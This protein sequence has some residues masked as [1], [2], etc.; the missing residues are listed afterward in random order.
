MKQECITPWVLMVAGV[1][2]AAF[3]LT[4]ERIF[5]GM[6]AAVV[7]AFGALVFCLGVVEWD[8]TSEFNES[9]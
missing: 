5:D 4:D 3:G 1:V 9:L 8:W 2:I 6:E 7:A